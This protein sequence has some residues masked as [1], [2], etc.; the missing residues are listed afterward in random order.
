MPTGSRTGY[1]LPS[2]AA[3]A[4]GGLDWIKV[5]LTSFTAFRDSIP[6]LSGTPTQDADGLITW[7]CEA[8]SDFG[9]LRE[10]ASYT[11]PIADLAA[12]VG[13]ADASTLI[14]GAN[15]IHVR[16]TCIGEKNMGVM[17][18]F[19]D[20]PAT[21]QAS[22]YGVGV[23]CYR[24]TNTLNPRLI[25]AAIQET[26]AVTGGASLQSKNPYMTGVLQHP[27]VGGINHYGGH[28]SIWEYNDPAYVKEGGISYTRETAAPLDLVYFGIAAWSKAGGSGV[29]G[30]MT[31]TIW[32]AVQSSSEWAQVPS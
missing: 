21:N 26:T 17:A 27:I 8:P 29:A 13:L 20:R 23:G 31:S 30:D 11:M 16:M 6:V 3:P 24:N 19:L 14:N 2:A 28:V 9:D 15:V 4:A 1:T 10:C 12:I 7:P 22:T 5:Q 25:G 32:V 18:S